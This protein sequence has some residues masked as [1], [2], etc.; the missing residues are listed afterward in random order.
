MF[1]TLRGTKI[2]ADVVTMM[3]RDLSGAAGYGKGFF[4][5]TA[6]SSGTLGVWLQEGFLWD[7]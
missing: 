6:C 3:L 5:A 4:Q 2:T 1:V 7:N